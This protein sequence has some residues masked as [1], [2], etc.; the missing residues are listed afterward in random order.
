MK[1]NLSRI[2]ITIVLILISIYFLYPTYQDYN[3]NKEL[4]KLSGADSIDFI[5]KNNQS[6]INARDKRIKLGLDLKGGMYVVLDVDVVKLLEDMSKKKDEQLTAILVDV[7][8]A[9]KNNE[10]L[11]LET[12]KIKLQ[13]KGLTLKNYYGE[14]RDNEADIESN[15]NKEIDNALDRAV[16]IVRNRVDQYG[17]A[18]PQIQKV[19]NSRIIVELPGV[20]N[21]D[22]VRQL[23]EGTALLEFKMVYDPQ[24][25]VKVFEAINK[26]LVGDTTAVNDS[27][28]SS[29]YKD[30]LKTNTE[31]LVSKDSTENTSASK[32]DS[33][34]K[35]NDNKK[36]ASDKKKDSL[37][38]KKNIADK[39]DTSSQNK[40]DSSLSNDTSLTDAD[41]SSEVDTTDQTQL[42]EEER[43]A[44][45][46]FFTLVQLLGLE[47]G[48][49]DGFV[50]ESDKEKVERILNRED[51]KA[52]IPSDLLLAW[53][54]KTFDA[55][56]EKIHSLYAVKKDAELTGKVI[57]DARSNIDP[58]N[59][60]PIVS[61][62]MDSEGAADWARITG[63]NINKRI[64]IVLDN[65]VYSAPV[66]RS[67]ITGGNS[68]IEGMANVQEAKLLEIVLKAGALP[69]PVKI[70]EE[71]SIGPSLGEDS[72]RSG[73]TSSVAALILV[74]LFMIF[75]YK[76]GGSIADVALL[77]NFLIILGCLASLKATLTLPGIAGLILSIGM[78]VDTNV[79]IFE[80]IREELASGKPL[81]T[82][83][84]LG[85]KRAFSA[86]IDSHITTIMT[87][88]ILYQFGS[89][90]I[91]GFAITLI[92]GLLANLFTA[93]VITHVIFDIMIEKGKK[94]S[95]G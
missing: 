33:L 92:F 23:L 11:I 72:I 51:V 19:G 46:P 55:E 9:S 62:E 60:T 71:R 17:V 6:L 1:K 25:A 95:F 70:I 43:Q 57:V 82:A 85:Y 86:I 56:G 64:A 27:V 42:S 20:S 54:N 63:A 78:S 74:A 93:I 38:E 12:F 75:Y 48:S 89:G 2:I 41:T 81:R 61:M 87:G 45:Y 68:Q 36:I 18:E 79:L 37:K 88:I 69:A 10:E 31:S 34:Q 49:A 83:V 26:V 15:L 5:E 30:S 8:E 91:Q 22:E 4:K 90:P 84:D 67:K 94:I 35:V 65:V 28:S 21:P 13:E 16:E 77:I 47:Q 76:F 39:K 14:V 7:K 24:A 80:R 44:K 59:N 40:N 52:V 3:L 73:I 58:T 66:V 53:S 50:K 29:I 32:K